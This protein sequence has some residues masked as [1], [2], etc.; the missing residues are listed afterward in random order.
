VISHEQVWR[1]TPT[2][3]QTFHAAYSRDSTYYATVA[4]IKLQPK[5][6]A[7]SGHDQ[8][9]S[10]RLKAVTRTENLARE[11]WKVV[12]GARRTNIRK[13]TVSR[14]GRACL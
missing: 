14:L 4:A 11:L 3:K 7:R 12:V 5:I 2:G 10:S 9:A 8:S 6:S 13:T 1:S